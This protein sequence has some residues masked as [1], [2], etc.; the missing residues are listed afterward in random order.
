MKQLFIFITILLMGII[1]IAC[2]SYD[3]PDPI[4]TPLTS[5]SSA[6]M[7]EANPISP[8]EGT[9]GVS[10]FTINGTG[11]S[12]D[13]GSNIVYLETPDTTAVADL[14][15]FSETEIQ[16]HR[17]GFVEDSTRITIV[18]RDKINLDS[19]YPYS[20]DEI[21]NE[22]TDLRD[23]L[24]NISNIAMDSDE[25]LYVF[26][27]GGVLYKVAPD[28]SYEIINTSLKDDKARDFI[29]G[30]NNYLY[31]SDSKDIDRIN[32]Q[33]G[34]DEEFVRLS[35]SVYRLG[36]VEHKGVN[37]LYAGRKSG[38]FAVLEDKSNKIVEYEDDEKFEIFGIRYY[39]GKLYVLAEYEG[40]DQGIPKMAI[41]EHTVLDNTGALSEKSLLHNLTI[42][43]FG[44][45]AFNYLEIDADGRFYV[46]SE[47]RKDYG[48][49]TI[50]SSG[51][52]TPIYKDKSILPVV[53]D[54]IVWGNGNYAYVHNGLTFD[55]EATN[56]IIRI[57]R[58]DMGINGADY[59][60]R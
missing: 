56:R 52:V 35:K 50:N 12:P 40:S 21:V 9:A 10:I 58:L 32:L 53:I 16:F 13:S 29:N 3:S 19:F 7:D 28:G 46:T 20:F 44:G 25:N 47:K 33:T 8:S 6:K 57:K 23:E 17:P 26:I 42:G 39:D 22:Y 31:Y 2:D 1:V 14:V 38:L 11:F 41:W 51:E 59:I 43:E 15:S 34:Q 54:R 48:I 24:E 55:N 18:N 30:P 37:I 60:G 5:S 45:E 4:Y 27:D 49:L 36:F